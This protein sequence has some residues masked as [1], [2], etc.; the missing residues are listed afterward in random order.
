MRYDAGKKAWK[1]AGTVVGEA[2]DAKARP[3]I[4]GTAVPAA[5][6]GKLISGQNPCWMWSRTWPSVRKGGIRDGPRLAGFL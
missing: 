5:P 6:A 1:Q 2:A 4:L 3:E